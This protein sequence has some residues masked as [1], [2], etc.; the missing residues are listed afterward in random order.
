MNSLIEAVTVD[1]EDHP[2]LKFYA[3]G[4]A[5]IS[6]A[7]YIQ[8]F[9]EKNK[10]FVGT[11]R[12]YDRQVTFLKD[13]VAAVTYC[14]DGTKTYPKD[15]KTGKVDRSIEASAS[16]YAFVNTRVTRNDRGVWQT[17]SVTSTSGAKKCM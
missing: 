1:A 16:D 2:A 7:E 12:Y 10:S 8:G 14:K 4:D 11:V 15:V 9:Q 5:L 6:S 17:D 3:T 13:G